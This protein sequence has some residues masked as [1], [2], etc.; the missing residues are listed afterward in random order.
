MEEMD[1]LGARYRELLRAYDEATSNYDHVRAH[2]LWQKIL[3]AEGE[4]RASRNEPHWRRTG[5]ETLSLAE[6]IDRFKSVAIEYD[7]AGDP[8]ENERLYWELENVQNELMRRDG[9]QRRKLFGLY[10]DVDVRVR[11]AAADAT[12]TLAPILSRDRLLFIDDDNWSPPVD[13]A[14]IARA[15]LKKFFA[16]PHCGAPKKA[17]LEKLSTK[18]LVERF[19]K[20][21]VLQDEAER[22]SKIPKYNRL[23]SQMQ[24]VVAELKKRDGDQR[25]ALTSLYGHD[26]MQ[27]RLAAA[28]ATL[29]V[30]PREARK[31]LEYIAN[32]G[33]FPQAGDAGMSLANL[34]RGIFKPT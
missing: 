29:A 33:W 26:N 24:A 28:K 25:A 7:E 30:T 22:H 15:R 16:E 13:G 21:G 27:V 19:A 18:E 5:L 6:V 34:D 8:P 17:E 23:F 11:A 12:R 10:T 4:I 2:N 9:D 3:V 31:V 1:N 14:D 20:I 32:S